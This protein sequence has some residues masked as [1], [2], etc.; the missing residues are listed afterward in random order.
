LNLHTFSTDT[1]R[2]TN[3][4]HIYTS[5]DAKSIIEFSGK[6]HPKL[7]GKLKKEKVACGCFCKGCACSGKSCWDSI[8][9]WW[10]RLHNRLVV[11]WKANMLQLDHGY[12]KEKSPHPLKFAYY[13][14]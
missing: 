1:A 13:F 10:L 11:Y 9:I 6:V 14:S 7:N 5:S 2:L 8:L 3:H 4:D 12:R